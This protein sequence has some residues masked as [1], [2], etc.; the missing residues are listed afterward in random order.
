MALEKPI[1]DFHKCCIAILYLHFTLSMLHI[2]LY[3]KE[4][5]HPQYNELN[6]EALFNSQSNHKF[7]CGEQWHIT[8]V[9]SKSSEFVFKRRL[10]LLTGKMSKLMLKQNIF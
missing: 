1:G 7:Y 10:Y 5:K 6:S 4:T 9:V 2:L 8:I 3:C